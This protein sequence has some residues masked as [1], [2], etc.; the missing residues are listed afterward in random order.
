[1]NSTVGILFVIGLVAFIIFK[2]RG[3]GGYSA[4]VG[5]SLLGNSSLPVSQVLSN[6]SNAFPFFSMSSNEFYLAVEES[7]KLHE[8]PD[9][10]IGR[11]NH[12]EGGMFSSSREYLRIKYRDLV[13]DLCAAPYGKDF[14]V[15]WWLY[16]TE[17]TLRQLLKYTKAGDYLRQRASKR[18]FFQA[19]QETMFRTCVHNVVQEVIERISQEQ[20]VRI[21]SALHKAITEGGISDSILS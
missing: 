8:I 3:G 13:F 9:V 6:W 11:T 19:D 7:I 14:F 17:G 4:S 1:M 16:E 21:P 5:N 2:A 10:K 15:S 18:T 20:G 12:K